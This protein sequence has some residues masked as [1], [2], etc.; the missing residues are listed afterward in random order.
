MG[1]SPLDVQ[2]RLKWPMNCIGETPAGTWRAS[3]PWRSFQA[4]S[5]KQAYAGPGDAL[6]PGA[7]APSS[8]GSKPQAL[9]RHALKFCVGGNFAEAINQRRWRRE[10]RSAV[11]HADRR[12]ARTLAAC[13]LGCRRPVEWAPARQIPADR[14]GSRLG[15][16]QCHLRPGL[17]LRELRAVCVAAGSRLVGLCA[18]SLGRGISGA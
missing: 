17:S 10:P 3:M 6:A 2:R 4:F 15:D 9:R 12:A 14:Y 7:A 11:C 8:N 18:G 16:Y 13:G 1:S 5:A